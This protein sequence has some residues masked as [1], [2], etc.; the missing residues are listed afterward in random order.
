VQDYFEKR[1]PEKIV[2]GGGDVHVSGYTRIDDGKP[3]NVNDYYRS[4]PNR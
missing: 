3:V 2:S 4:R 1:Y